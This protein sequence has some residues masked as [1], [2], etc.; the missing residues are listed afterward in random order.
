MSRMRK[1]DC[2]VSNDVQRSCTVMVHEV[3]DYYTGRT[4]KDIGR[5]WTSFI[6]GILEAKI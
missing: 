3:S 4:I 2:A 1:Q 6:K 5:N